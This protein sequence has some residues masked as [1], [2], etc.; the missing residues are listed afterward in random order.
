MMTQGGAEQ[1][2]VGGWR[3]AGVVEQ[4]GDVPEEGE[5]DDDRGGHDAPRGG[6]A[7]EQQRGHEQDGRSAE[8]TRCVKGRTTWR[9]RTSLLFAA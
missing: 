2:Q 6:H 7:Q 3:A 9:G 8:H 1:E 4:R 5:R